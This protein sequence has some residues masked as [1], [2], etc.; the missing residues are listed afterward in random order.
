V[1]NKKFI[2]FSD[3]EGFAILKDSSKVEVSRRRK[4][5]VITSLKYWKEAGKYF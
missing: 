3:H 2:L 1:V 4:D 5:E